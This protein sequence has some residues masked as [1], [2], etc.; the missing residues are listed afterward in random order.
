MHLGIS[1]RREHF[2]HARSALLGA[3]GSL[4]L[5]GEQAWEPVG[6]VEDWHSQAPA[7]PNQVLSGTKYLLVDQRTGRAY[8]LRVGLNRLGRF[9]DNDL[10]FEELYISRRH[11]VILVHARGGCELHD[12]ASRNGTFRNGQRVREPV[13]LASGDWIRVCDRPLLF[14]SEQDYRAVPEDPV[15]ATAFA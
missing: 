14:V 5:A 6:E 9:A 15:S 12:T 13:R 1:A 4:T 3:R 8:P 2:R 10:V 11:C 7:R